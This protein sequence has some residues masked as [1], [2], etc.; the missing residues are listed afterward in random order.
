MA[1]YTTID[2]PS[3]YFK[4]Q[5]YTGNGTAIGSGGNAITFN[6]TDTDMQPDLVWIK[7]RD[8]SA[9]DHFLFDVIRGVTNSIRSNVPSATYTESE[10]LTAFGSDG[11]TVGSNPNVN[12]NTE[13]FV[14]WCWKAG[15]SASA[16]SVG[17]T[18][19]SV[20]ANTTSGFSI[21]KYTNPSS[22]S[23]FTVGHSIGAA[24]KLVIIK[25]LSTSQTW[26]VWHLGIATGQYL[27]LDDTAAAASANLVTAT[28]STTF[29][30]YQ[31][32]H[33]TGNELIA[34]C[35]APIQGFSKFGSYEG[36]NNA[37]GTFV[38]CGF[39]PAF[40]LYKNYEITENWNINDSKRSG[41]NPDNAYLFS[42]L[43]NAESD[44]E[45]IDLL[46]NGFKLR[47]TDDEQNGTGYDFIYAAFAEAPLVNSNGVPCNAR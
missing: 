44:I 26:G 6:D 18:A 27:R 28:S 21:V 31:D 46:S 35:F 47:T 22:G 17:S 3:A 16:N 9:P 30:T 43:S 32:H 25:N 36:N 34:Y 39:R 42:N 7:G 20:S 15:G 10:L 23:P 13:N 29:S 19:S 40:V 14:S 24:P 1:A 33:S 5:L 4:V 41:Y 11:F 8:A 37:D 2:D 38:F 12:T 45:R